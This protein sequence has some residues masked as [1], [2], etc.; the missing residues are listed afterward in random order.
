MNNID[1]HMGIPTQKNLVPIIINRVKNISFH[2]APLLHPIS[3]SFDMVYILLILIVSHLMLKGASITPK[4][5]S[6][7]I[8]CSCHPSQ[9]YKAKDINCI[10]TRFDAM[11][12]I[13]VEI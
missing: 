7:F 6:I 5:M 9:I 1:D 10:I 11:K 8:I 3:E 13:C 2:L 12:M 4:L